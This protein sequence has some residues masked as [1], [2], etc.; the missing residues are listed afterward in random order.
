MDFG[1]ASPFLNDET[2]KNDA[3]LFAAIFQAQ[4]EDFPGILDYS[5]KGDGE[6]EPGTSPDHW[7][8]WLLSPMIRRWC[9]FDPQ[10]AQA[11][12]R[13]NLAEEVSALEPDPFGGNRSGR[14]HL[15]AMIAREALDDDPSWAL[16]AIQELL[17]DI[18]EQEIEE[19][20]VQVGNVWLNIH[21]APPEARER[22]QAAGDGPELM[23]RVR[24]QNGDDWKPFVAW[25]EDIGGELEN[26][27]PHTPAAA[28]ET[29]E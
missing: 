20:S 25:L 17:N 13:E 15:M 27:A 12:V 18:I 9:D 2:D 4:A 1:A 19:V 5:W 10:A 29:E 11:W 6:R 3:R 14:T 7:D 23:R 26:I 28:N 22:A 24:E 16:G 21:Q 8:E